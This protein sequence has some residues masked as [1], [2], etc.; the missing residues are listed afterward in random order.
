MDEEEVQGGQCIVVEEGVVLGFDAQGRRAD[1][2][3]AQIGGVGGVQEVG[4]VGIAEGG[5]VVQEAEGEGEGGAVSGCEVRAE[6][7]AE[8]MYSNQARKRSAMLGA[9]EMLLGIPKV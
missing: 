4:E 8:K 1:A 3:E 2:V 6:A 5:V 9:A 7:S